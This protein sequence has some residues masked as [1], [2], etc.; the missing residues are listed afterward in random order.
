MFLI[1]EITLIVL[2]RRN[3]MDNHISFI[4]TEMKLSTCKILIGEKLLC[5]NQ[6]LGKEISKLKKYIE[7]LQ[8]I[9]R[10]VAIIIYVI[11]SFHITSYFLGWHYG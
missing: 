3:I 2:H 5:M 11:G 6:V 4:L 10:S 7:M 9:P 8:V 1:E